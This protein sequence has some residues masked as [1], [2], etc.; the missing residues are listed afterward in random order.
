[1]NDNP[2]W[3]REFPAAITVCDRC[4]IILEMNDK[5]K[6]TFSG[7][8]VGKNA[9]D[10]HPEPAR[11]KLAELLATEK[12]NVYTIEKN[13]RKKFIYQSPWYKDGE[14]AGLV[15]LSFEL[16]ESLPHFRRD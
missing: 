8:L 13:G 5:A 6:S 9:L 3:S 4:G 1:M 2:N 7:N 14:F 15:E 12:S 10:C 11:T 16:P